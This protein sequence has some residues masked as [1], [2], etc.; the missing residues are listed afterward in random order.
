MV[1][2]PPWA[3]PRVMWSI[4]LCGDTARSDV[5]AVRHQPED[6]PARTYANG[7]YTELVEPMEYASARARG[8]ARRLTQLW[9]KPRV[10]AYREREGRPPAGVAGR[11]RRLRA[12][13]D[14]HLAAAQRLAANLA[15]YNVLTSALARRASAVSVAPTLLVCHD[16]YAL[17]AAARVKRRL[18]CR[19]LYDSHEFWSDADLLAQPWQRWLMAGIERRLIRRADAVVTVTPQLARKL[20][21]LHGL[22]GVLSVPNARPTGMAPVRRRRRSSGPVRFVFH[23]HLHSRRGIEGLLEA[24]VGLQDLPVELYLRCYESEYLESL[25]DNYP[26]LFSS[27]RVRLLPTVPD[28]ELVEATRFADVGVIPYPR[29]L[30]SHR[31]ACPNKLAEYLQAGL[32]VL[33]NDLD[34]VRDLVTEHSCGAVYDSSRPETVT[35]AV[36]SLASDRLRLREMQDNAYRLGTEHFNWESVSGPYREAVTR[37]ARVGGGS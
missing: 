35:E 33:T 6:V 25:R 37:L 32:A 28:S 2:H 34:F 4:A 11:R 24:W 23:G 17:A 22:R 9:L 26:G 20:E 16:L 10:Q 36:R 27:R 5:L 30:D 21:R 1:P 19:I 29:N 8:A 7:V 14:H 15:S 13:A 12:W 18:Q 31:Y 3:D